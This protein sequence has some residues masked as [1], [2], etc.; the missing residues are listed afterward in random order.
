M[1]QKLRTA[2]N[3]PAGLLRA[4][5]NHSQSNVFEEAVKEW[6]YLNYYYVDQYKACVCSPA[7][8]SNITVIMNVNNRKRMEICNSCAERHFGITLSS[9]IERVVRRIR[10][11]ENYT[12]NN[13]LIDYMFST[14]IIDEYEQ[15]SYRIA[16]SKRNI[17]DA[18]V[19]IRASLN[20]RLITYTSYENKPALDYINSIVAWSISKENLNSRTLNA[21]R[22][23]LLQ[24]KITSGV[25]TKF[26]EMSGLCYEPSYEEVVQAETMMSYVDPYSEKAMWHLIDNYGSPAQKQTRYEEHLRER[27]R[28]RKEEYFVENVLRNPVR[29]AIVV[30]NWEE[31]PEWDREMIWTTPIFKDVPNLPYEY[32]NKML[33]VTERYFYY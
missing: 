5:I 30:V 31:I 9:E 26:R 32:E 21:L 33:Y 14:H 28:N 15:E 23:Q 8:V 1:P 4:I 20:L 2:S 7:N 3:P 19:A 18:V 24:K 11:N 27:L 29:E 6:K 16:S 13:E 17:M 10:S 12:I 25:I 22:R